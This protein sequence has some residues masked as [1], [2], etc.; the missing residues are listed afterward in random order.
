[1]T[2]LYV[3]ILYTNVSAGDKL[4]FCEYGLFAKNHKN[5]FPTTNH[6]LNLYVN[7]DIP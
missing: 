7:I 5:V 4:N 6:D 2:I 3:Y 1:M